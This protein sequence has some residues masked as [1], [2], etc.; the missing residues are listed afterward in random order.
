MNFSETTKLQIEKVKLGFVDGDWIDGNDDY[1][2]G[3]KV[4][5]EEKCCEFDLKNV[6]SGTH[7]YT[8]IHKIIFVEIEMDASYI[9]D[10]QLLD[11][12]ATS[13]LE[14]SYIQ[15][16]ASPSY[17]SQGFYEQPQQ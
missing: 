10:C 8:H 11:L 17:T 15:R 5:H 3:L 7:T 2:F 9:N 4:C 14:V 6:F 16:T 12:N 13:L 1:K